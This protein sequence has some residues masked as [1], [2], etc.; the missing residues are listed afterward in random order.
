MTKSRSARAVDSAAAV[1]TGHSR[2]LGA[3]VAADLLARGTRVLG[4]ARRGNADLAQRYGPGLSEV[5]LD[6]ADTAAFASWLETDALELFLARA[7]TALLVNNAGVVQ[8]TGP[9]ETQ[10]VAAVSRA[11]ALNVGAPLMLAAAFVPASRNA[12]ERRILHISSGAGRNA[13]AG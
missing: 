4:V 6:L 12:G 1:V 7:S 13:Y 10:D 2:G 11:V 3:A 8:P 5:R 9:L